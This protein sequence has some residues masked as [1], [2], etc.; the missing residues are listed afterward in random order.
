MQWMSPPCCCAAAA[1]LLNI[2]PNIG[3]KSNGELDPMIEYVLIAESTNA[4]T[5]RGGTRIS[6]MHVGAPAV[7]GVMLGARRSR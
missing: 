3:P 2:G 4:T 1:N 5:G 6:T 7:C